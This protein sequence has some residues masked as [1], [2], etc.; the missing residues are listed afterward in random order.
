MARTHARTRAR[1]PSLPPD[2][3]QELGPYAY[4]KHRVKRHVCFVDN[5]TRVEFEEYSFHLPLPDLTV[6]SL[7]DQV[8]TLNIPLVGGWVRVGAWV[9]GWAGG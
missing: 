4:R 7:D 1:T 8:T 9:G 6:G 3:Q 2:A 5:A